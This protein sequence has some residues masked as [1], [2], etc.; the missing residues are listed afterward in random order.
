[1]KS[2]DLIQP[3]QF[4]SSDSEKTKFNWFCYEYALE[5]NAAISKDLMNEFIEVEISEERIAAFC[6]FYSKQMKSM[7]L[8]VLTGKIEKT[9]HSYKPVEKFFPDLENEWVD[10]LLTVVAK[11]WDSLLA[12]CETCPTRCISEKDEKSEMFDAPPDL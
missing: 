12:V 6:I 5:I 9:E 1:M 4:Y 8:D 7:I 2:S 11:A 3:E 10:E